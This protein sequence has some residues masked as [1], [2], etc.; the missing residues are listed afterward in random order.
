MMSQTAL[1]CF[2]FPLFR[3]AAAVQKHPWVTHAKTH[4]SPGDGERHGWNTQNTAK[5]DRERDRETKRDGE[6]EREGEAV[7]LKRREEEKLRDIVM[8]ASPCFFFSLVD[9]LV[10]VDVL[11]HCLRSL[12]CYLSLSDL[13]LLLLKLYYKMSYCMKK[14]NKQKID[15]SR[16]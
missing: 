2:R 3:M 11:H 6:T 7:R 10:K 13:L 15:N 16:N 8:C 4:Q 9:C 14:I 1:H 12:S 5:G